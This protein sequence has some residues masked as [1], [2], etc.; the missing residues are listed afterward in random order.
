MCTVF[1]WVF[2]FSVHVCFFVGACAQSQVPECGRSGEG[3][4][5]AVSQC[6]DLQLGGISGLPQGCDLGPLEFTPLPTVSTW[7]PHAMMPPA[8]DCERLIR[9]LIW[10]MLCYMCV[11]ALDIWGLNRSQV[12]VWECTTE[13]RHWQWGEKGQHCHLWRWRSRQSVWF[14]RRW[15]TRPVWSQNKLFEWHNLLKTQ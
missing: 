2:M 14:I 11:F 10:F 4:H 13:D 5:T 12:C 3:H 1:M 8:L 9:W 15:E 7:N 6:P